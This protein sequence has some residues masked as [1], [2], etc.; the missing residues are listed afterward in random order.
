MSPPWQI[1]TP[2]G[3]VL[4]CIFVV[5]IAERHGRSETLATVGCAAALWAALQ[6]LTRGADLRFPFVLASFAACLGFSSLL[7]LFI[8]TFRSRGEEHN[9]LRR[10]FLVGA[11]FPLLWVA[12]GVALRML[13]SSRPF[14]NDRF[15]Y[16]FDNTLGFQ[17]SFV[18]GQ[19]LQQHRFWLHVTAFSYEAVVI[20]VA[21]LYAF[22]RLQPKINVRLVPLWVTV[23][24]AGY[25][26]YYLFP[27][28]GPIYA[29]DK[30][31]PWHVV[32]LSLPLQPVWSASA[33]P[34]NCVPSIHYSLALL[35]WWNSRGRRWWARVLAWVFVAVMA[36]ATLGLGEHYLADLVVA[37]PFS[38]AFQALWTASPPIYRP[39]RYAAILAPA[40]IFCT[41]LVLLRFDPLLFQRTPLLSWACIGFTILLCF[42]LNYR[43]AHTP[44]PAVNCPLLRA[45]SSAPLS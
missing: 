3:S 19:L 45:A 24:A 17:P 9:R 39:E 26:V 28:I 35:V 30:L 36:V 41:W 29:F 27:A 43:L 15:L 22:H 16:A 14:I 38:L 44:R 31:Y 20:P 33:A 23:I 32:G 11:L 10:T 8:Q 5:H 12:V 42:A 6:T 1:G 40:A 18:L 21:I 25:S 2:L 7:V 13:V 34:R 4:A 37:V